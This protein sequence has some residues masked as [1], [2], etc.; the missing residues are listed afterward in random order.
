M[1]NNFFS[2]ENSAW[3]K[4]CSFGLVT[5]DNIVH[6]HWTL[7]TQGYKYRL[8]MCNIYYFS[9]A[10]M[11]TQKRLN[12]ALIRTMVV[13]FTYCLCTELSILIFGTNR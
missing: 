12:I 1:A 11:V 10:I 2:S 9:T 4:Y 3:K 13:L 6:A 5:D 7:D 8:R